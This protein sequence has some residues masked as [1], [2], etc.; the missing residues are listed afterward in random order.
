MN[1]RLRRGSGRKAYRTQ[2]VM[3]GFGPLG[4]LSFPEAE[5]WKIVLVLLATALFILMARLSYERPLFDSRIGYA[6]NAT[7]ALMYAGVRG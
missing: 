2:I 1:D 7:P 3:G 4:R 6:A 5:M